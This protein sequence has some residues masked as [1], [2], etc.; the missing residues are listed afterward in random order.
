MNS[1]TDF[2]QEQIISRDWNEI[3]WFRKPI[4]LVISFLIFMPAAIVIL[5]T[6][7]VFYKKNGVVY[8]RSKKKKLIMTVSMILL[9]ATFYMR[10]SK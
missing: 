2:S 7:D 3:P 4:F 5:W 9:M 1:E 10:N 8:A 6:G